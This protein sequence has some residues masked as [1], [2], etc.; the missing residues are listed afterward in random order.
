MNEEDIPTLGYAPGH[1]RP[2]KRRIILIGGI[3]AASIVATAAGI[4]HFATRAKPVPLGGA[5]AVPNLIW[6][7]Q[8]AG[9][10]PTTQP[11][12]DV[13]TQPSEDAS[14]QTA[15]PAPSVEGASE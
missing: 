2:M 12:T 10:P 3:G 15:P 11:V 7:T 9:G 1:P 8:P 4:S 6:Q 5:M 13:S 14:I